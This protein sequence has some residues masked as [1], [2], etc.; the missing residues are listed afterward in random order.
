[1]MVQLCIIENEF[2]HQKMLKISFV[3]D[4]S[5]G[6]VSN[7]KVEGYK[8]KVKEI[9][10]PCTDID[11]EVQENKLKLSKNA[12]EKL[13]AK[14]DDRISI[15]YWNEGIGKASPVI[16]KAEMFTD[17]LDGNRLTKQNTVSFRGEKRA[18]LIEFGTFFTLELFKEGVWKL[19]PFKSEETEE[20][21]KDEI[22]DAEALNDSEI[23]KEIEEL[24]DDLP[25]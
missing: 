6:S 23:D 13:N 1:M 10:A 17:R 22:Q 18:T 20:N 12:L 16:G 7:V 21:L 19:V 11:L 5:S 15:Q 14:A 4:E 9:N 3:F 8:P 2:S 25:F 24:T